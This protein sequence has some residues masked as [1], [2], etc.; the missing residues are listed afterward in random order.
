[1]KEMFRFAKW[2][3]SKWK[4]HDYLWFIGCGLV[5]AGFGNPTLLIAGATIVFGM[6]T[7]CMIKMQWARYKEERNKLFDTIKDS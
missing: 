4:W 7:T 5:G 1:M 2:H 3:F 6:A